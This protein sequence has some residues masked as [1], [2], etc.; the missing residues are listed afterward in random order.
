MIISHHL[1]T[2]F[3]ILLSVVLCCS[4]SCAMLHCLGHLG[5]SILATLRQ[6]HFIFCNKL[7][8]FFGH[9][10]PF[11]KHAKLPFTSLVTSTHFPFD[12]G[13]SDIWTSPVPSSTGHHYCILFLDDFTNY[14]W[15]SPLSQKSQVSSIFIKFH[16]YII[17]QF[18]RSIKNIQ[19]D[20]GK[21]YANNHFLNFLCF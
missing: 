17:T 18:D 10:C 16:A 15:T 2:V 13:H 6:N 12:I 20:N 4:L 7:K 11:S 19:R 9:S 21:E 1:S 14:L 8:F 5:P 3:W